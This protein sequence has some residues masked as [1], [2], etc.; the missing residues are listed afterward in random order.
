MLSGTVPSFPLR[1]PDGAGR[2]R[3][4]YRT[5]PHGN[6]KNERPGTVRHRLIVTIG[7]ERT[8]PLDQHAQVWPGLSRGAAGT[9]EHQSSSGQRFDLGGTAK[10]QR[11]AAAADG[12]SFQLEAAA[13][14]S[15][16]P[17]F[18][19]NRLDSMPAITR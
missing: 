7:Q 8:V 15:G 16:R 11:N 18:A 12:F 2:C 6:V 5:V 13:E 14:G 17:S 10:R 9:R 3:R 19:P 4:F 1:V